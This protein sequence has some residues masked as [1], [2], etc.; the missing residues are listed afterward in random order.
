MSKRT[1]SLIALVAFALVAV[2]IAFAGSGA[3][4]HAGFAHCQRGG[5]VDSAEDVRDRMDAGASFLLRRVDATDEQTARIDALLD[6]LA[7]Q[8]WALKSE[9]VTLRDQVHAAL[10][11]GDVDAEALEAFRIQGIAQADE[12][13]KLFVESF[14]EIAPPA[15]PRR[16]SST[17][18]PRATG[19]SRSSNSER[20]ASAST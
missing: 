2:P 8:V 18:S 5:G 1:L 10:A 3:L 17:E 15:P 20:S 6:D 12:A 11:D 7:P 19:S 14:V 4:R 16:C 9:G 13:S